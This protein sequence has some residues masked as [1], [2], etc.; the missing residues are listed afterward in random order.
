MKHIYY[1]AVSTIESAH[2]NEIR[3]DFRALS[4]LLPLMQPSSENKDLVTSSLSVINLQILKKYS[5][6]F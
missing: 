4:L 5:N 3:T 6:I 2:M 1:N